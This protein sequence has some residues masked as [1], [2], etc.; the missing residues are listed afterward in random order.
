MDQYIELFN[1]VSIFELNHQELDKANQEE[2]N[3]KFALAVRS[4]IHNEYEPS[5]KEARATP[6][7]ELWKKSI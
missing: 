2:S 5:L 1:R 7:A 3:S 6:I 4:K